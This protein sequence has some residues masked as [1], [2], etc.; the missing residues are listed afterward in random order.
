LAII[1]GGR[2]QATYGATTRLEDAAKEI[3]VLKSHR[4]KA[5]PLDLIQ[6]MDRGDLAYR[7]ME[8]TDFVG[9]VC[10]IGGAFTRAEVWELFYDM[11]HLRQTLPY[12]HM[13]RRLK[14]GYLVTIVANSSQNGAGAL[15]N[16]KTNTVLDC[17]GT[18]HFPFLE[19]SRL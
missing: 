9:R 8:T 18:S 7:G 3:A 5:D 12:R 16:R 6:P 11:N 10:E 14:R 17:E 15:D 19:T 4:P 13:R 2:F 1:S